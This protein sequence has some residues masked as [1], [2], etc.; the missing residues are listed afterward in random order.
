MGRI[1]RPS[2]RTNSIGILVTLHSTHIDTNVCLYMVFATVKTFVQLVYS[3]YFSGAIFDF[4]VL[5]DNLFC[6]FWNLFV[7]QQFVI[8]FYI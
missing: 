1:S 5:S 6:H 8:K 7:A 4:S 2:A 3:V